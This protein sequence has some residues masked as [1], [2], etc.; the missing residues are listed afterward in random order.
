MDFSLRL[1]DA[2]RLHLKRAGQDEVPVT[3]R[4][5]FPWS[6]PDRFVSLRAKDGGGELMLIEDVAAVPEPT[7]RTLLAYL[8]AATFVPRI[9]RVSRI[10]LEHGYQQWHVETDRGPQELRVQEREDVR[11]LSDVRYSVKDANGNLYEIP[12]VRQLDEPSQRELL[13]VT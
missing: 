9:T 4:R 12:D 5:A 7:R 10:G 6:M 8:D 13:K 3:A 11:F 2:G 1:D